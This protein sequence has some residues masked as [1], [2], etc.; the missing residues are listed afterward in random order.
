[1]RFS[2]CTYIDSTTP[3]TDSAPRMGRA[4]VS[5]W[6]SWGEGGGG[7]ADGGL[8]ILVLL[9]HS[10]TD[11]AWSLHVFLT[12]LASVP[13]NT[14]CYGYFMGWCPLS[15][16]TCGAHHRFGSHWRCT[17]GGIRFSF[18]GG[19][20]ADVIVIKCPM[21][22]R[23]RDRAGLLYCRYI[24]TAICCSD[25]PTGRQCTIGRYKRCGRRVLNTVSAASS[26]IKVVVVFPPNPAPPVLFLRVLA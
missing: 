11:M 21:E 22:Q 7:F 13:Y 6:S 4:A 15:F 5:T 17:V 18:G 2:G 1:M 9:L 26:T 10:T 12:L 24:I 23:R 20:G 25:Y 19:G 8:G 3:Y 14:R 16:G